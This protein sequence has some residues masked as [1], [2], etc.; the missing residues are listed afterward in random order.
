MLAE[1]SQ[2]ER[3]T[4]KKAFEVL[5]ILTMVAMLAL[6]TVS[7]ALADA[8][9][10]QGEAS[11][12]PAELPV[13]VVLIVVGGVIMYLG[14]FRGGVKQGLRKLEEQDWGPGGGGSWLPFTFVMS[15][16]L[17]VAGAVLIYRAI[18]IL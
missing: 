5:C 11:T 14:C 6:G 16:M 9:E 13:G 2:K 7:L 17:I 12:T 4:M 18:A 8:Q 1:R 3:R 15:G 10:A